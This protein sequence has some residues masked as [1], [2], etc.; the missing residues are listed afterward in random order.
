MKSENP[1]ESIERLRGI[2]RFLRR[3][4]ALVAGL[5]LLLSLFLFVVIGS[6][7]TDIKDSEPLA[8]RPLLKPSA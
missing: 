4:P 3:N 8:A 1:S 2:G 5:V 7:I 6:Y